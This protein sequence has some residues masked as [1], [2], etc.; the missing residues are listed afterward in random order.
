MAIRVYHEVPVGAV[1]GVNTVYIISVPAI[2]GSVR[3]FYRGQ[4]V[5]AQ[6]FT[7]ALDGKTITLGFTPT[8]PV[9]GDGNV[10]EIDYDKSGAI[11]TELS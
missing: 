10:I 2:I 1:D 3:V 11:W 4:A 6:A 8:A 7:V 9:P 5:D